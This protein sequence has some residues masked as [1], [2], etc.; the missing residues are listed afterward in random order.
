[1]N[2]SQFYI[3]YRI[4]WRSGGTSTGSWDQSTDELSD[5]FNPLKQEIYEEFLKNP[6]TGDLEE[7]PENIRKISISIWKQREL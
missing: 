1:M 2:L 7:P 4:E 6:F 5:I 3:H